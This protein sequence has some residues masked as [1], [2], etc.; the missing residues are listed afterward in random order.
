MLQEAAGA[1]PYES[2]PPLDEAEA[3]VEICFLMRGLWQVG[4]VTSFTAAAL[5]TSSSKGFPQSLHTNS[6]MGILFSRCVDLRARPGGHKP[7]DLDAPTT[8]RLQNS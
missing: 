1:L 8:K 7:K 2:A 4:Q 3:K 5:R 6:K